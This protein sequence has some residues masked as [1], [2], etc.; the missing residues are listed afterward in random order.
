MKV[1]FRWLLAA[2]VGLASLPGTPSAALAATSAQ[3]TAE[4][5]LLDHGYQDWQ[6]TDILWNT[7]LGPT[8]GS[9]GST[10]GKLFGDF[11][12]T[13]R[14]GLFDQTLS[15]GYLR[16]VGAVVTTLETAFSPSH[17]VMPFWTGRAGVSW[18]VGA[19]WV[20]STSYKRNAYNAAYV[21]LGTLGVDEYFGPFRIGYRLFGSDLMNSGFALSHMVAFSWYYGDRSDLTLIGALGTELDALPRDSVLAIPTRTLSLNL[22]HALGKSWALTGRAA[23]QAE[24]DLYTRSTLVLGV[25]YLH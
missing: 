23:W 1:P 14:F 4:Y 6:A 8:E 12:A 13:R 16:K 2:F 7:D 9:R 5:S 22:D 15:F 25:S 17:Q 21:N 19:G 24:G 11:G 20:L 3:V 10:A 18:P